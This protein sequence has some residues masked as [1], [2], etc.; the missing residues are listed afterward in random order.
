MFTLG[1]MP[2]ERSAPFDE[3]MRLWQLA[4]SAYRLHHWE[5]TQTRLRGLPTTFADTPFAGLCRQ[6]RERTDHYRATPPPAAWDGAQTFDS[7]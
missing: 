5:E 7:Q 1:V 6:L 3:E 4:L 2:A